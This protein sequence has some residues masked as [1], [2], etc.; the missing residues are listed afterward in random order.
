MTGRDAGGIVMT[1]LLGIAGSLVGGLLFNALGIGDG[2][3]WAGLFGAVIG[4][5]MLLAIYRALTKRSRLAS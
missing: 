3:L 5:I 2:A 1:I 4:A